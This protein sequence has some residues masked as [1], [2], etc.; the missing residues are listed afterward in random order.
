MAKNRNAEVTFARP[1]SE[2]TGE[3][4]DLLDGIDSG[5]IGRDRVKASM[6]RIEREVKRYRRDQAER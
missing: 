6:S 2:I 1:I 4:W 5:S 3:L